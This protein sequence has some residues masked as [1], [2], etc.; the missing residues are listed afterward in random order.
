[1]A[2]GSVVG[3]GMIDVNSIVSQLMQIER[4]PLE[5]LRARE[6]D[7]RSKLSA[8]GR[9]QGALSALDG[10]LANLRGAGAFTAARTVVSADGLTASAGAGAAPGR[11]EVVVNALARA[12]TSASGVF[13]DASSS[14]GSGVF[15]I[16]DQQGEA[17]AIIGIG[18]AGE[19]QT[20]A[21][22]R[23]AI[24]AEAVGV[25]AALVSDAGG[26]RLMLTA[27]DTGTANA[28]SIEVDGAPAAELAE[29]GA[30]PVQA[31]ADASL[32]FNG[33]ALQSSS[34]RIDGVVEGLSIDLKKAQPGVPIDIVVE[35][36]IDAAKAAVEGFVRA[37]ND[38]RKLFDDL[39]K[40][41]PVV[42]TSAVLNGESVLRQ[43]Q[44]Q[45]RAVLNAG[46]TAAPGE[47]TRLAEVGVEL[48]ADG[49]LRLDE[50]KFRAAAE[51]G[52]GRLA[53]LFNA[54][55]A[56]PAEQG[57]AVRL[58]AVLRGVSGP[59]GTLDGRQAG[60][61]ASM[62]SL[63]VQQERWQARLAVIEKRLREQ[64]SRLDALVAGSQ[65]QSN[66]LANALAALPRNSL[67]RNN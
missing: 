33:L 44:S 32:T 47:Y 53:R 22:L 17:T 58:G 55:A 43:I 46:R 54:S 21:E 66:A 64:Y 9:V 5:A 36:D 2:V 8:F 30:A 1:M 6:G 56:E 65:A 10:A 31:A 67:L 51:A 16:R 34:N 63:D 39:A 25:R 42:R 59:D 11:Y 14:V 40:Y 3:G 61:R 24:N 45:F 12:Q 18:G 27:S 29:L 37:Y 57:I 19:P 52:I 35:R 26:V 62:R 49:Q 7:I 15:T 41:D 48:K 4:R 60:L 28:F 20:L 13:A 23:D 38:A 50:A